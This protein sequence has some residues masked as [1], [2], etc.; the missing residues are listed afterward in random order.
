MDQTHRDDLE[1]LLRTCHRLAERGYVVAT[2]GNVSIRRGNGTILAT[3]SGVDKES[4]GE[5]DLV[6]VTLAG[7]VRSAQWKPS[8]EIGM[9]LLIYRERQDVNA[10]VHAHPVYATA[11]AA[12]RIPL[13]QCVFPEIIVTIGTIPLARYATPSTPEVAESL[14]PYVRGT[15]AILLANH[16]VVT[17]GG[18]LEEAFHRMERVEHAA[19]VT[20]LARVLGGEKQLTKR[21]LEQLRSVS[22][23]SYGVK[24]RENIRNRPTVGR[25]RL[26]RS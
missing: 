26:R 20:F 11:F 7:E 17:F 14:M 12:A 23:Q 21:Q 3:R 2:D 9:H 1:S 18:T 13:D 25:K 19:Q 5:S 10:I 8:T 4:V 22:E 15:D 24:I 6:E 16:G